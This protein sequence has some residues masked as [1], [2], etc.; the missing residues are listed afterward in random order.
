M[1]SDDDKR[2]GIVDELSACACGV[3]AIGD[4]LVHEFVVVGVAGFGLLFFLLLGDM[5]NHKNVSAADDT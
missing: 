5:V 2:T 4:S 1:G 3:G